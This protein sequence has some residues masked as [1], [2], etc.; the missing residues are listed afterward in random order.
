MMKSSTILAAM[1]SALCSVIA[2]AQ[3]ADQSQGPALQEIVIT[4][5]KRTEKLEDARFA[6]VVSSNALA[7]SNVSDVSDLNKLVQSLNINGT[8]SGRA[9]MGI[10]GISSVSNEQAVGVPSGVAIMIDGVPVPSDSYDGNL[11]EDAQS[12]EV[13]KG[14]QAT[15]GGRTAASGIINYVTYNPTDYFTGAASMTATNDHEWRGSARVSGPIASNFEFSLAAYDATRYFP[16]TNEFY[17]TKAVQRDNGA[18]AKLLWNISDAISAKLTVH[19]AEVEQNGFNFV[20]ASTG[21]AGATL[22]F[23]NS[24]LTQ[25]LLEP[26]PA[27]WTNLKYTSPVNTAGHTQDDNDVQFDLNFNLGSGYTLT[28]TTAYQHENQQQIQDIFATAGYFFDTLLSGP[29]FTLVTTPIPTSVLPP[30]FNDVQTQNEKIIQ[31]A[32]N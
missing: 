17:G 16:V 12:V 13:L 4:A 7:N 8:I 9:P 5:Q 28:S 25:S 21:P 18:C 14:P 31:R 26:N 11:I 32:K 23:P 15:L 29:P 27:S 6:S 22:L 24:P 3:Q 20:Y 10:R 2:F 30:A 19:H 1:L